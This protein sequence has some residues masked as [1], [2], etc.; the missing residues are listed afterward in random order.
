M[1]TLRGGG[2]N[3][4]NQDKTKEIVGVL[5]SLQEEERI[6]NA[7]SDSIAPLII[8]ELKSILIVIENSLSY[9]FRTQRD[10]EIA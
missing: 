3:D 6:A 2:I 5:D 8:P 10:R 9:S 1:P 4:W 7:I